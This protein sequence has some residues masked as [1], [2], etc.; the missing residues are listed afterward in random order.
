MKQSLHHQNQAS[1]R[2]G[3][4][5]AAGEVALRSP[6]AL[7]WIVLH[8]VCCLVSLA[9]GFRFSRVVFFL[10]FSSST[11]LFTSAP[12]LHTVTTT[13]T[14]NITTTTT[15]TTTTTRTLAFSFPPPPL[16]PAAENR[17][18]SRVVVGRQGIRIR[19]WPH[20]DPAET[21][22]AHSIIERVQREQRLPYG[23]V[24][25]PRPLIVVTPTY[26]RTFQALHLTG[27]IHSLLL[28]P[29][30]LTWIVV[31]AAAPAAEPL[32]G[33]TTAL[34]AR[35]GLRYLHIPFPEP[36]PD[37]WPDRRLTEA[38]M[39][40]RALRMIREKR[41]D[42][43]VVF[44]DDSN[45]HST[46]LFEEAQKV[47]WI[48]AVS[49]GILADTEQPSSPIKAEKTNSPV[50]TQGPAC[51]SSGDFIGWRTFNSLTSPE[52]IEWAGFLLNSRLVW[53][54]A[55]GKPEWARDLDAASKEGDEMENPL[56]LLKDISPVEPLGNC[57]KKVLLWWLRAEAG[58][59]SKFPPGSVSQTS[60]TAL[61]TPP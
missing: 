53:R 23:A 17:T 32:S 36:M 56:A 1:R 52:Q 48:G 29:Y 13:T 8:A 46:E 31:E 40:L 43:V 27:L 12:L 30:P 11:S 18:R 4:V 28:V 61:I 47:N 20:P 22:R 2:A 19:P 42:G 25:T 16:P 41:M 7:F 50:P 37:C 34:L 45:V 24:K 39:R 38:R 5:S 49:V 59:G 21:M 58:T 6:T 10:F 3:G 60:V 55:K 15:T 54:E 33:E 26:V 9:L 51:N 44:A 14:T 57:G 35:S